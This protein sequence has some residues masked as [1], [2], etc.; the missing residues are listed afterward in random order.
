MTKE[1]FQE[2]ISVKIPE[3]LFHVSRNDLDDEHQVHLDELILIRMLNE[4]PALLR[5]K[6]LRWFVS[7][8]IE[9]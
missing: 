4:N 8:F 3:Q 6:P 2:F 1:E 5:H 7:Y 9:A